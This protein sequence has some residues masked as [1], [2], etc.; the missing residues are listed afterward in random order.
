[1]SR[2]SITIQLCTYNRAALLQRVLQ[3]CF[4]QSVAEYEVVLINDG[5]QDE[6]AAIIEHAQRTAPVRFKAVTHS[7]RGLARSRNVGIEMASG[8]R[9]IFIDDDVLPMPNFV[10]E[11]LRTARRHPRD[12]V[13]GGVIMTESFDRLPAPF[14]SPLRDYSANYFWTSNVS[15]PVETLRRVGGFNE[16][17]REYGWE[18]IDVGLRLRQEGLRSHVNPKALAFHYKPKLRAGRVVG[19]VA[20]AR[21]QARTAIELGRLHQTWRVPLATGNEPVQRNLQRLGKIV[22]PA[23]LTLGYFTQLPPEKILT[24]AEVRA[25]R[26]LA[27]DAYFEELGQAR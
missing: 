18:D 17:F 21:A 12:V 13:R 1:M 15:V 6:T 10:E 22:L 4:E 2:P 11:H 16:N 23:K 7:N 8:Q 3:G 24:P 20:Q 27:R 25:A 5:S 26:R 14:W 9:I 19:M